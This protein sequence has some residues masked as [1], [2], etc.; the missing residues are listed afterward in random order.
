[1]SGEGLRRLARAYG[2]PTCKPS[3]TLPISTLRNYISTARAW[4][5]RV[6]RVREGLS[7]NGPRVRVI[8]ARALPTLPNPPTASAVAQEQ[9][10]AE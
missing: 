3:Q 9:E 2:A 4:L 10:P 1:M 6:G 7:I 5:G 8:R